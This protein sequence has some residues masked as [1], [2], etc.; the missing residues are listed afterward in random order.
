VNRCTFSFRVTI[1]ALGLAALWLGIGCAAAAPGPP[2]PG[3]SR[4]TVVLLHGLGRSNL[5]MWPISDRLEDAGFRVVRVGYKSINRTPDEILDEV[6]AQIDACCLALEHPVHMVGHSLGGL[7][8]RAYLAQKR[9]PTL[10]RVVLMGTPNGGTPLVD[11][12]QDRWWLQMV[13]ETALALGTGPDSFPSTLPPPDYPVGVIAGVAEPFDNESVI[14]GPDD[15]LVPVESTKVEGMADFVLIETTH[16]EMRRDE[17]VSN[18][19]V[20]FLKTGAFAR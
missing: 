10:G 19:T 7:L 6:S 18:Q 4:Q 8:I 9:P 20:A 17:T 11:R 12:Y 5:A 1:S 3:D 14:P 16:S 15:G 2:A 13:G